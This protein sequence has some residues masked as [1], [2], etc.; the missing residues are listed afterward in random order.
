MLDTGS[1]EASGFQSGSQ[2]GTQLPL[3][4]KVYAFCYFHF[5]F[6]RSTEFMHYLT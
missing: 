4:I 1:E 5:A 2:G 3:E 6:F